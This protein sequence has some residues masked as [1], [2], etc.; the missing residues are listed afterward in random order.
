MIRGHGIELRTVRETDLDSLYALL[1]DIAN[2]GE[3]VPSH[4]PSEAGFKQQ[5]HENGFW[6]EEYGRLLIG[7]P[8]SDIV[9]SIWYF[10]SIPYFDGF[11]IGYTMF[12]PVQRGQGIMTEALS[13]FTDYLF[14]IK[15]IHRVQL[16]IAEGNLASVKVAQ[17]CGF[18]YEGTARQAMYQRG[19]Y[20]DMYAGS[21]AFLDWATSYD[22]GDVDMRSRRRHEQWLSTLPC[23]IICI[24]GEY[25]IEEQLAVLM[26]EIRQ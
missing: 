26:G 18:T 3:F 24:E 4:I 8:E 9:G 17:K 21:Q 7:T 12:D 11:E 13:L 16:I 10:K 2:R 25:A 23:P 14:E 6:S 22:D 19:Q 1:T 5:F 15:N 20:R